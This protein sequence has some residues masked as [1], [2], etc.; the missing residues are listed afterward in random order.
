MS[1]HRLPS[2]YKKRYEPAQKMPCL[3]GSGVKFKN[4]CCADYGSNEKDGAFKA[5][6][7]GNYSDA[8]RR[9][10]LHITWYILCH[11]AHT[12]PYLESGTRESKDL[13]K[14]DI[15]SMANLLDL[16]MACYEKTGKH[17][18]FP[19]ALNGLHNAISDP[20]WYQYVAYQRAL[21]TLID[22]GDKHLAYHELK[23]IK[24]IEA[25]NNFNFLTLYLNVFPGK[26]TFSR[27]IELIDKI[28]KSNK[29][30]ENS[31]QYETL[32]GIE[33]F[34]LK[35]REN[36]LKIISGAI[37]KFKEKALPETSAYGLHM[38]AKSLHVLGEFTGIKNYFEES[39]THLQKLLSSN[40][41]TTNGLAMLYSD[42]GHSLLGQGKPTEAKSYFVRSIEIK[43]SEINKVFLSK[44][45]LNEHEFLSAKLILNEI[46]E[47]KLDEPE[48]FDF[49]ICL[50][51]LAIET[52]EQ[53]LLIRANAILNSLKTEGL[54]FEE[55]KSDL[56]A[57]IDNIKNQNVKDA[58]KSILQKILRLL[59]KYV[60][61]QPNFYGLGLNLNKL[62]DDAENGL[63]KST[64][65]PKMKVDV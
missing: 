54:L 39:E 41:F 6:S 65:N 12:I 46:D 42:I 37:D 61:I 26:L 16:L 13:L 30:P 3:C 4:C 18:Q 33:F 36:G 52:R 22:S 38:L 62:V 27:K 49:V 48:R 50:S 45:L 9:C 32:K 25:I 29:N 51:I 20:R 60:I 5:F 58:P 1:N 2:D 34:L 28:L 24:D 63:A 19:D 40:S 47:A 56:I 55:L 10:R 57:E 35:D 7:S 43:E 44:C 59:N 31:L 11:R 64:S 15:E 17:N 14:V 8:L 53:D 21:W 23:K